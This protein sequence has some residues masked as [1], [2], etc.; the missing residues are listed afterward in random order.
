MIKFTVSIL[1]ISDRCSRGKEQ[2]KSGPFI[3]GWVREHWGAQVAQQAIVPDERPQIA[4][5]LASW[6]DCGGVDLILTTG[7][8]GIERT[9]AHME[10]LCGRKPLA[11]LG[12]RMKEVLKG[13]ITDNIRQF[14]ARING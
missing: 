5:K 12:L 1:T 3:A 7:G 13:D 9:F 14:V 10:E 6:S 2:D 8:T 4:A 11:V